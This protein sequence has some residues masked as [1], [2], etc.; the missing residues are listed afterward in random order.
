MGKLDG[1]KKFLENANRAV[2][3]AGQRVTSV[4]VSPTGIVVT[5]GPAVPSTAG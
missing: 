4:S 1:L 5:T 3:D 2:V